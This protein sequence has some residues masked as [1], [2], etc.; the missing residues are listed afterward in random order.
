MHDLKHY[1]WKD[2]PRGGYPSVLWEA[3]A[4]VGIVFTFAFVLAYGFHQFI[5]T[6]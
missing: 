5:M 3:L 6:L 4:I 2:E 1:K